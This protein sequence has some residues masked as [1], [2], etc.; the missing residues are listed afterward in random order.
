ML[1]FIQCLV[2]DSSEGLIAL[3]PVS[4]IL[5]LCFNHLKSGQIFELKPGAQCRGSWSYRAYLPSTPLVICA[6]TIVRWLHV[7]WQLARLR[8]PRHM[9]RIEGVQRPCPNDRSNRFTAAQIYAKNAPAVH[10]TVHVYAMIILPEVRPFHDLRPLPLAATIHLCPSVRRCTIIST[11]YSVPSSTATYANSP[12]RTCGPY[13]TKYKDLYRTS[14]RF[15]RAGPPAI[16][17][18]RPLPI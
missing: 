10:T 1:S 13:P 6:S 9:P 16:S 17:E 18:I 4:F 14:E 8:K 3:P 2:S 11:P 5:H 7:Y 12:W 15:T